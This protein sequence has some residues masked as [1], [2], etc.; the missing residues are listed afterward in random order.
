MGR[1]GLIALFFRLL[2]VPSPPSHHVFRFPSDI[3]THVLAMLL[4]V[5]SLIIL[6][7]YLITLSIVLLIRM[8]VFRRS[9]VVQASACYERRGVRDTDAERDLGAQLTAP[10][11]CNL[12]AR[13][14]Q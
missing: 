9:I 11:S 4:P 5:Y 6:S 12:S 14:V 7:F 1:R 8:Y 2:L 13:F 10:L 3:A